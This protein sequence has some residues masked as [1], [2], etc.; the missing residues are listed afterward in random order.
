MIQIWFAKLLAKYGVL[1]LAIAGTVILIIGFFATVAGT[2]KIKSAW[3]EHKADKAETR[4]QAAE[5]NV[6]VLEQD[7]KQANNAI[8]IAGDTTTKQDQAAGK[9]RAET[10]KAIEVIHERII[11]VPVSVN[12]I[13]DPI[14][15]EQVR[16][17][18]DRAS[19][20]ANRVSGA[21]T[22]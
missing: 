2:S 16:Q 5:Q 19:A 18:A 3:F 9:Q 20:A 6:K 13:A 17:A 4:A 15:F 12:P 8:E 14:V 22:P 10:A 1:P 21:Q 11:Q 7:A